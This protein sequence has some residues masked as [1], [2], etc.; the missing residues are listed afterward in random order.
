MYLDTSTLA[1]DN[2]SW[3]NNKFKL[4]LRQK[5]NHT[6]NPFLP[7][8]RQGCDTMAWLERVSCVIFFA[9]S[10]LFKFVTD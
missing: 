5:K 9:E 3:G 2:S 8:H 6:P 7:R 4:Y 1:I 10:L